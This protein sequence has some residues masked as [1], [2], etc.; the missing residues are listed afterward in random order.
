MRVSRIDRLDCCEVL[1][2]S[3]RTFK[4]NGFTTV[5]VLMISIEVVYLQQQ[6]PFVVPLL[7]DKKRFNI[8]WLV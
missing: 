2:C 1:S 4:T 5:S 7:G 3:W 8:C 6:L